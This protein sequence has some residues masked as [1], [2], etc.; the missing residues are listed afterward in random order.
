MSSVVLLLNSLQKVRMTLKPFRVVQ[1]RKFCSFCTHFLL[2]CFLRKRCRTN[3]FKKAFCAIK[4]H[5]MML[6]YLWLNIMHLSAK[7][8]NV[9]LGKWCKH[10]A[11]LWILLNPW[12]LFDHW[13]VLE[14]T[15]SHCNFKKMYLWWLNCLWD[16]NSKCMFCQRSFC[17]TTVFPRHVC[18]N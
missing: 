13:W 12:Y 17:T 7:T 11:F 18:V 8:R 4:P 3:Q 1:K 14:S 6:Y 10:C 2:A 9:R 16:L 15:L 5:D